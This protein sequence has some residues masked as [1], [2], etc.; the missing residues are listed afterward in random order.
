MRDNG[1]AEALLVVD[2]Q[3]DFLP[4]G[5]LA[6]PGGD[7]VL[8]P[9][10]RCLDRFAER[11]RPVFLTRD[12]HPADHCSFTTQ[13]GSWPVHCVGG[14]PGAAFAPALHIPAQAQL[15][16]KGTDP[17]AEAYS[18]FSATD[19]CARLRHLGI[20]RLYVG[21]LATDYCVLQT[22]LDARSLGFDARVMT[23]AVAAVDLAPGDGAR[24]IQRM[25]AAGAT[26]TTSEEAVAAR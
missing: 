3:R 2:V 26:L 23:D 13:G 18:A 19:L 6:V 9:L 16:S 10:Q 5:A 4:G 11:A 1:A 7:R 14:T 17:R 20:H 24:A 8:A 25:Q 12:W 15:V 22:V 21:G